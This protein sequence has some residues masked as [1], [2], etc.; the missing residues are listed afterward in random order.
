[1]SNTIKLKNDLTY[2]QE[3]WL[4][5]NIGPKLYHL[6]YKFGGKGWYVLRNFDSKYSK[7]V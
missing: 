7:K 3:H 5:E 6:H 1:M 2:E 4:T